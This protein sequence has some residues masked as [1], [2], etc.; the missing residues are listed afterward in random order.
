MKAARLYDIKDL[1]FEDV[2]K[3]QVGPDDVLVEV[4]ATGVCGTD[5]EMYLGTIY[6]MRAGITKLPITPGHEWSGIVVEV[7]EKVEGICVGD[8]VSGECTLG[9]MRCEYCRGGRYNLCPQRRQT[10]IIGK[11]GGFAQYISMPSSSIFK[12]EGI[13]FDEAALIEPTGIAL[14]ATRRAGISPNSNVGILGDGA[15]GLLALQSARTH[16]ARRVLLSGIDAVKLKVAGELGAD[17]TVNVRDEDISKA[18]GD[19]TDGRMMDVVVEA[20]GDPKAIEDAL[21]II[22][23]GGRIVLLGKF[24]GGQAHVDW[25]KVVIQEIEVVGSLG[26]PNVWREAIDLLES[27][28]IRTRPLISLRLPLRDAEEAIQKIIRRDEGI[29]KVVLDPWMP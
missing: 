12:F 23:P 22:R 11:D 15:V 6:Y 14:W 13:P 4:K 2:D 24:A 9:C 18:A 29:V 17:A 3:P 8:R 20:T 19:L 27:G 16:G 26:S 1:R 10:G 21:K 5:I 25:D 28:R 7:G